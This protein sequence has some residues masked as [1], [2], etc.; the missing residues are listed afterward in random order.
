M[1]RVVKW[2]V[3]TGSAFNLCPHLA[4]EVVTGWQLLIHV[5]TGQ[6]PSDMILANPFYPIQIATGSLGGL[7][8]SWRFDRSMGRYAFILPMFYFAYRFSSAPVPSVLSDSFAVRVNYFFGS[9]CK[10]PHCFAQ[11]AVMMPLYCSIA[12]SCSAL[13]TP[14]IARALTRPNMPRQG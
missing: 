8:A 5:F 1:I 2:L 13:A 11:F 4:R 3:H 14:Y 9:G 10:L 7:L 6:T 12:Y